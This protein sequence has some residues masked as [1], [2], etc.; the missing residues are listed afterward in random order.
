MKN[1]KFTY[2]IRRA[3]AI[4]VCNLIAAALT[5]GIVF[6]IV[7]FS[8]VEE[9][10]RVTFL[11]VL[12]IALIASTIVAVIFAFL[13][14]RSSSKALK[15]IQDC[16]NKMADGDFSTELKITSGEEYL[17][18]IADNINAVEKE[19]NSA[20]LLKRDFIRNFSHEFKTPIASIQ[21]FAEILCTN[22]D[23]SDEDKN[24]YHKIIYEESKR[25]TELAD[26]TIL[27]N[28]LDSQK[29]VVEKEEF[30]VDQQIEE[31]AL[32]LYQKVEEKNIEVNIEV[33]HFEV[34]ASKSLLKELW[35]NLFS[36]AVKYTDKDGHIRIH[37]YENAD[38]FVVCFQDDGC[39]ISKEGKKHIFDEY[40]RE[41]SARK[42]KGMGL[43]LS[44]CKRIVDIHG[45]KIDVMSE[46]GTG[47]VFSVHI[48]KEEE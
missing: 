47:S 12:A 24:K 30:Y 44:I 6:L 31:C 23:L 8:S 9:P 27:I 14:S 16:L 15:E 22:E 43:G 28:S 21:G 20:A 41:E 48:P 33:E 11:V 19:L 40:Y 25:L 36:N 13:Q 26:S 37:S 39:G 4:F 45:W 34:Y 3:L 29:V 2:S 42:E 38:E 35:L 18:E 5:F 17:C 10:T 1:N 32:Q 46:V 7:Y